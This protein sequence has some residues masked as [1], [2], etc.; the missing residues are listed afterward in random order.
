MEIVGRQ[1]LRDSLKLQP[2]KCTVVAI[3][4]PA[5][6][7]WYPDEDNEA[8]IKE[9]KANSKECKIERFWDR[10]EKTSVDAPNHE[11]VSSILNWAKGRDIDFVACAAGIS[12]STALGILIVCQETFAGRNPTVEEAIHT[13]KLIRGHHRPNKLILE[14]GETILGIRGMVDASRYFLNY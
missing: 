12:R 8:I 1:V 3:L 10:W 4:E 7:Q 9:V 6:S 2:G 13:L 14:I 11:H 5:D